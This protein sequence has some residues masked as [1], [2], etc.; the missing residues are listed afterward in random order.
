[1][2]NVINEKKITLPI[3]NHDI[4]LAKNE[5][6]SICLTMHVTKIDKKHQI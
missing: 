1:M 6:K 2:E 4:I 3:S 5:K